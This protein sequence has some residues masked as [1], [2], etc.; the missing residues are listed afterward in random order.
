MIIVTSNLRNFTFLTMIMLIASCSGMQSPAAAPAVTDDIVTAAITQPDTIGN[1]DPA[2]AAAGEPITVTTFTPTQQ[3]GPYYP[4]EK[5]A[6]R[7]NDLVDLKG[8]A[9]IPQGDVL[10][11][12][13]VVY[14]A[15]GRPLEGVTIEIWQTDHNG[16]YLHPGDPHYDRRDPN[17]QFYGESTT[18]SDGVYSFLTIMPGLYEPRPRH[19]HVRIHFQ[20]A[21]LLTTQFYFADEAAL[22]GPNATLLIET[23]YA[24]NDAGAPI[25]IGQRDIFLGIE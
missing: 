18:G 4:L 10:S 7:D 1:R 9:G 5:P 6:D 13:G 16:I 22:T 25:L 19:I 17:F 14:G 12:A 2:S 15:D 3:Q 8:A 11:L 20:G 24:E 21:E 23:A